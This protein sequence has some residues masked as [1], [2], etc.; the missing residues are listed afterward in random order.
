[1]FHGNGL[2]AQ[3][4]CWRTTRLRHRDLHRHR[5]GLRKHLRRYH[6]DDPEKALSPLLSQEV[7]TPHADST[8]SHANKGGTALEGSVIS[9]LPQGGTITASLKTCGQQ[10]IRRNKRIGVHGSGLR[11]W[12]NDHCQRSISGDL[13]KNPLK[14]PTKIGDL[15]GEDQ[16][17]GEPKEN[18][19]YSLH[20]TLQVASP[21]I[22]RN[23]SSAVNVNISELHLTV[24][25]NLI[26][27]FI[28]TKKWIRAM[29][30]FFQTS[31]ETIEWVEKS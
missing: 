14:I 30:I 27:W 17:I 24:S 9:G 12:S 4:L 21:W 19:G 3:C 25:Q 8:N 29:W 20:E 23:C 11:E 6:R 15:V 16:I 1:M 7:G 22:G 26:F 2:S 5:R 18:W 13:N 10:T 31:S 28:F